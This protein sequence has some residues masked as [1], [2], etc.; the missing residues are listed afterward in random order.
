MT[1]MASYGCRIKSPNCSVQDLPS[2]LL[3]LV[4]G[5]HSSDSCWWMLWLWKPSPALCP[6]LSQQSDE[7]MVMYWVS[8]EQSDPNWLMLAPHFSC[9]ICLLKFL[10]SL[11]VLITGHL[12]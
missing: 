1:L 3:P 2:V 12:L 6:G 11:K 5:S 9:F 7:R 8:D 4:Q 10:T